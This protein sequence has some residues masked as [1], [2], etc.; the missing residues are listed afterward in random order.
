M[1]WFKKLHE[2][3][4]TA[5]GNLSSSL[6][7]DMEN[8]MREL[9][10]RHVEWSGTSSA[11]HHSWEQDHPFTKEVLYTAWQVAVEVLKDEKSI[12]SVWGFC[13]HET[14]DR[15]YDLGCAFWRYDLS[16]LLPRYALR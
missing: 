7:T 14:G 10:R 2:E 12:V 6:R 16:N 11:F 9:V 13:G 5:S 4:N 15:Y 3:L 1:F 8:I